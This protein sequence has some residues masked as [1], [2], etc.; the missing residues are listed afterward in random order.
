MTTF[1]RAKKVHDG[2]TH[3]AKL[4]PNAYVI[5]IAVGAIKENLMDLSLEY[6]TLKQT[7]KS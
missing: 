5:M 6:F 1:C 4:F 2:V 7:D 3:A